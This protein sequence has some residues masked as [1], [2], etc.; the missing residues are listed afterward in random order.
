MN[1][2]QLTFAPQHELFAAI[3]HSTN[4]DSTIIEGITIAN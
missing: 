2:L 3:S 4:N 1:L